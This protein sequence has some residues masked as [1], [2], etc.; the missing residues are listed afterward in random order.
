MSKKM[1]FSNII[2][3]LYIREVCRN[4]RKI[5]K[6]TL[7][8]L[9]IVEWMTLE[10]YKR[11]DKSKS[12]RNKM[13]NWRTEI[14]VQMIRSRVNADFGTLQNEATFRGESTFNRFTVTFPGRCLS[15]S[16]S[17]RILIS[18]TF[19][20]YTKWPIERR[21]IDSIRCKITPSTRCCKSSKLPFDF[22]ELV[23]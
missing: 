23:A 2:F 20:Q 13:K 1:K 7:S 22:I 11:S 21:R 14:R 18:R 17:L 8:L 19:E 16:I 10:S 12:K 4:F 3:F 5:F 6:S 9:Q 15:I